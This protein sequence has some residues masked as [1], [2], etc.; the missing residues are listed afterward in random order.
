MDWR[1]FEEKDLFWILKVSKDMYKESYLEDKGVEFNE[2]A[3]I[4][5]QDFEFWENPHLMRPD[6]SHTNW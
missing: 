5:K 3:A 6:G 4:V 1:F 2:D